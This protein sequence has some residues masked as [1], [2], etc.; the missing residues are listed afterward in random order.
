MSNSESAQHQQIVDAQSQAST[1]HPSP[2]S[3]QYSA[4]HVPSPPPAGS[5]V[6][7]HQSL[8]HGAH[9]SSSAGLRR[10]GTLQAGGRHRPAGHSPSPPH[11]EEYIEEQELVNPYED[12]NYF[13]SRS[14]PPPQHTVQGQGQ[15]PT[16]PMGRSSPW[17]TPGAG[18]WRTA[19]GS[20]TPVGAG[21]PDDLARA[22]SNLDINHH[23]IYVGNAGYQGGQ[24]SHPPRFHPT[25]PPPVPSAGMR[26][27]NMQG[28][29]TGS[30]RKL[31]LETGPD[32]R[33]TPTQPGPAPGSAPAYVQAMG[34]QQQMHHPRTGSMSEADRAVAAAGA[35][36]WEQKDKLLHQRTSNPNLNYRFN[37]GQKGNI[38]N[39]PPIPTQYLNQNQP[40][41]QA[42]RMGNSSNQVHPQGDNNGQPVPGFINSPVDVPS[43]IAGKGYNPPNFDVRP[44]FVRRLSLDVTTHSKA[45]PR[46]VTLSSSH[47]QK[48]M[49][50]N[51]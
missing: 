9:T 37:Q 27:G 30:S 2:L 47:T 15:Y 48:M 43:L 22:L 13:D 24:S 18:E 16:S 46:L 34:Q 26:P 7:R 19:G 25:H 42:P 4:S 40:G 21:N 14:P 6:R 51:P 1:G 33:K 41:G 29:N 50:T 44:G 17:G 32:G 3:P 38:P 10:A 45:L 12:E 23:N 8:T 20:F 35:S 28:A 31:Q 5:S 39:V 36:S 11:E 49:F